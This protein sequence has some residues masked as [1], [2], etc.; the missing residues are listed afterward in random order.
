MQK[1]ILYVFLIGISTNLLAVVPNWSVNPASYQY[2]MTVSSRV[3]IRCNDLNNRTVL[4]GAFVNGVCRG[5]DSNHVFSAGYYSTYITIFSNVQIGEK[6][7]FKLYNPT[8]DLIYDAIDTLSF[9]NNKTLSSSIYPYLFMSNYRPEKISLSQDIIYKVFTKD[10]KI[11]DLTT[12]DKNNTI[13]Q[14]SLLPGVM[15]NTDYF[16]I[17]NNALML[18]KNLRSDT[19]TKLKVRVQTDDLFGCTYDSIFSFT[20]VNNDPPPTG[21]VK[22]DSLIIE[23][24]AMG[25]LAKKL[26]A[27]DLSPTDMHTYQLVDGA[28]SDGNSK[29]KIVGNELLVNSDLEYSDASSYSVRIKITDIAL[30]KVEVNCTILIKEIIY[31][32]KNTEN[33]IEEHSALNTVA[34]NI[35]ILDEFNSGPYTYELVTGNG[36][37]DNYRYAFKGNQ[38][39]VNSDIEFDSAMAHNLRLRVT[40]SINNKIE[41]NCN[42]IIKETLN[43]SQPLK[44]NNFVTPNGD[45]INDVFEIYNPELYNKFHLSIYDDNGY[46][47]NEFNPNFSPEY[48]YKN[49]WNGV[50]DKGNK[51]PTGMYYYYF[52][53][54]N[55]EH[56]FKG[57]IYLVQSN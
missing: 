40:N 37:N 23:H 5:L 18:N 31:T 26:I 2:Q 36:S 4:V 51:L 15:Y 25:F 53:N 9:E 1:I 12:M 27:I 39:I 41:F 48:Q 3:S 46:L 13:F 8:T 47:V 29:F 55:H 33:T 50:S 16:Y 44:A 17:A 20:I 49:T 34:K 10:T 45:G 56:E 38:I 42:I 6:V 24:K 35:E 43:S 54:S 22:T 7:T 14:Y 32:L 28:G 21:L 19:I 57:S 11:A 52:I 30:N